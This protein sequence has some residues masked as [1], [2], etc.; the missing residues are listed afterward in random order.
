[1]ID[2]T[3]M[4]RM[5]SACA[6]WVMLI[7]AARAGD[8][9]A[10][11]G[12][13]LD[14]HKAAHRYAEAAAVAKQM[15]ASVEAS[16]PDKP[17]WIGGRYTQLGHV[18]LAWRHFTDA[19][20]AYKQA[21]TLNEKAFGP[22]HITT[23][24]SLHNLA[25]SYRGQN[26]FAAAEPLYRRAEAI[27]SKQANNSLD[28]ATM[29]TNYGTFRQAKKEYAEAEQLLQRAMTIREKAW[30][31]EDQRLLAT[32]ALL[33]SLY[34]QQ[35]RY[36]DKDPVY[37]RGIAI[38]EK[39]FGPE[40][41]TVANWLAARGKSR[42]E[43]GRFAEAEPLLRRVLQIREKPAGPTDPGVAPAVFDLG[44]FYFRQKR[45]AEA[46]PLFQRALAILAAAKRSESLDAALYRTYLA[47]TEF[48]ESR[49]ADA[50]GQYRRA[51]AIREKALPPKH[52]DIGYALRDLASTL[53]ARACYDEAEPLARRA[54]A[55]MEKTGESGRADLAGCLLILAAA[56]QGQGHYAAGETPL[57]RALEIHERLF[58]GKGPNV[59]YCL[60]HLADVYVE[61][62]R[63]DEAE[64][65]DRRALALREQIQGPDHVYTAWSLQ[66]LG[67]IQFA[68]GRY[69]EALPL[70]QR[71]LKI[72][73]DAARP[74]ELQVSYILN[75]MGGVDYWMGRY[76]EGEQTVRK[77]VALQEKVLGREHLY[78]ANTLNML[79][80]FCDAQARYAEAEGVYQR[81][82]EIREKHLGPDHPLLAQTCNNLALLYRHEARFAE[83]EPLF[84]RALAIGEKARGSEHPAT[85]RYADN[86]ATLEDE[87]GRFAEA[88][89]LHQRALAIAEK[90]FGLEHPNVA[91]YLLSLASSYHSQARYSDAEPLCRRALA[92][93]EKV[94]GPDS[95]QTAYA[96]FRL[97]GLD[98][99]R[100]HYSEAGTLLRRA[101]AIYEKNYGAESASA[102]MAMA[103]QAL[104]AARQGSYAEAEKNY[105]QALA[106]RQK[107]FGPD[108]PNVAHTL[109]RYAEM[110][111]DQGRYTEAEPM[112]DRAIAICDRT[113]LAPGVRFESYFTRAQIDWNLTEKSDALADLKRAM[114]LAEEQRGQI[115]GAEH[116]RAESFRKFA[117]AFEQ[118]VAWQVELGDVGEAL[119]AIERARARSLLDEMNMGGVDLLVG[120]TAAEREK[121]R[122][123]EAGL[124]ARVASL[125]KQL[126]QAGEDADKAA[127]PAAGADVDKANPTPGDNDTHKAKRPPADAARLQAELN[128]AREALYQY[129][130][131]ERNS[132]PVYHNLLTVE[133]GLPRLSQIQRRLLANNGLLLVYLL[134]QKGGYVLTI[135][136]HAARLATLNADLDTAK[137]LGIKIGPLTAKQLQS[138]L[139]N[140]K[141]KGIVQLLS[142]PGTAPWATPKLAALWRLLIPEAQRKE[143]ADGKIK[144]LIVIPDGPLALLPMETLVVQAGDNPK[145][146]LDVGPPI[147]YGPSATVLFNLVDRSKTQRAENH[148]PILTVGDAVYDGAGDETPSRGGS[149]LKKLTTR[150][151]YAGLGRQLPPLPYSG[152]ES[153]WVAEDFSKQGLAATRL[154]KDQATEANVR[155]NVPGSRIIHLACHGLAEQS[156]GNF[157]GAL[158][159]TPGPRGDSDP[160]DDGFLTLAEIYELNLKDCELAILSAC[161][162]NYGPQ[163]EGEGVWALSRGFLV[164][165][166][167]RVVA[168]NWLVDDEAAASLVSFFC[169][170]IAQGEKSGG[171][172]YSLALHNAKRWIRAQ[173]KWH[174]P[175]YWGTFV[176]VGPN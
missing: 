124:K 49:Y 21:L 40:H 119:S 6:A 160:A 156:F 157:F 145:Y 95:H 45:F 92:I 173:E 112:I 13:Q 25:E 150:S 109:S 5:L 115:A 38:A 102:A 84:K 175:F 159:L 41:P 108:H 164:A 26:R 113:H 158:I 154:Q 137:E 62:S 29:L 3:S 105:Q 19:E 167:R 152:T 148:P 66:G 48:G 107:V 60:E 99:F 93:H 4:C 122:Q 123:E 51:L 47:A 37:A 55:I 144:R 111:N 151:R 68:R 104:A 138:A 20:A 147:L 172:D 135:G 174:N 17:S 56:Y 15:I 59:A 127:N 110:L 11:L 42:V 75:E 162:T 168:S 166:S 46:E 155:E 94:S 97:G 70:Y 7:A 153:D 44:C 89:P 139:I 141:N 36:S 64:H 58:G 130:R 16:S 116:E 81:C 133:A 10:A 34:Q 101:R 54:V 129:Y 18:Y 100:E 1:M 61:Q 39:A 67:R 120:R 63:L 33:L 52:R 32:L 12:K 128:A 73:Q 90:C 85:A 170:G 136:E 140:E 83:A 142:D 82:M 79:A 43:Q 72:R 121:L 69:S 143:I 114:D 96:L 98:I 65:A 31:T 163:Q 146:L 23:A 132:N 118:M 14:A 171:A 50:E 161:E 106:I 86:L 74:D 28:A 24:V 91:G 131:D 35:R 117:E 134:G 9:L 53:N 169:S 22:E 78:L 125:E 71:A 80:L 8:D 149:V 165:G 57:K 77:A 76:A 30:G 87:Q 88:E 2:N 126:G 27:I 103:A 176:L